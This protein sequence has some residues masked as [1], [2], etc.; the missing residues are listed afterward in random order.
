VSSLRRTG[1]D[2]GSTLLP[3]LRQRTRQSRSRCDSWPGGGQPVVGCGLRSF[4]SGDSLRDDSHPLGRCD[5]EGGR[6]RW[7]RCH[8]S[9]PTAYSSTQSSPTAYPSPEVSVTSKEPIPSESGEISELR[10]HIP[11]AIAASCVEDP[12]FKELTEGLRAAVACERL[13]PG[14]VDK[15]IYMQYDSDSSMQAAYQYVVEVYTNGALQESSGCG[16]GSARG[17]WYQGPVEA[18]SFACYVSSSLGVR[19]RWSTDGTAILARATDEDM[20][21]PALWTWFQK[22]TTGPY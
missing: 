4:G 14:Y 21:V 9:S 1:A 17:R 3:G 12:G 10:D 20:S 8:D 7:C 5:S 19:L 16:D 18:G 11:A 15:I 6:G 22:T 13:G 2:G